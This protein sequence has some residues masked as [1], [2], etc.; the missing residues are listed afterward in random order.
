MSA[1]QRIN[2][3]IEKILSCSGDINSKNGADLFVF[4]SDMMKQINIENIKILGTNSN[5]IKEINKNVILPINKKISNDRRKN[6]K[7]SGKNYI[8]YVSKL[9]TKLVLP[10]ENAPAP[11][12]APA[13][14]GVPPPPPAP[15][16]IKQNTSLTAI[17]AADILKVNLR[18]AAPVAKAPRI[19]TFIDELKAGNCKAKLTTPKVIPKK[20]Q[21]I[22]EA[23]NA[24]KKLKPVIINENRPVFEQSE[25]ERSLKDAMN[26]RRVFIDTNNDR[27][28]SDSDWED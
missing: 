6:P 8:N 15:A 18:T 7:I 20:E 17:N 11:A 4:M 10:V 26:K 14:N 13:S 12:P 2:D 24:G 27:D 25:T 16:P 22:F 3:I 28:D 23:I 21:S 19:N 1:S 5:E 9:H